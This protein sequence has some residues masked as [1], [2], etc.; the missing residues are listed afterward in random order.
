MGRRRREQFHNFNPVGIAA[1]AP[2]LDRP[3]GH[4][5]V[6]IDAGERIISPAVRT[7][8]VRRI[9]V[10]GTRSENVRRID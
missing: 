8:S 3:H 1:V 4:V 9:V 5:I 2:L 6:R 10:I 7:V